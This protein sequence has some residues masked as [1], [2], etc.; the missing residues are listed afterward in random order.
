MLVALHRRTSLLHCGVRIEIHCTQLYCL[1]PAFSC[2]NL[3]WW[4]SSQQKVSLLFWS[5][6]M[7]EWIAQVQFVSSIETYFGRDIHVLPMKTCHALQQ[8]FH[9]LFSTVDLQFLLHPQD[10]VGFRPWEGTPFQRSVGGRTEKL[11]SI[12]VMLWVKPILP[13]RSY[14]LCWLKWRLFSTLCWGWRSCRTHAWT[15]LGRSATWSSSVLDC[16]SSLSQL[17][18]WH[19][20]Q[21]LS[22]HFFTS[23]STEYLITLQQMNQWWQPAPS[24]LLVGDL[25]NIWEDE[26]IPGHWSLARVDQTLAVTDGVVHIVTAQTRCGSTYT[27]PVVKGVPLLQ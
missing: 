24:F 3:L 11:K 4:A 1:S 12:S 16:L 25:V 5:L 13:L 26:T 15:F 21:V 23:W 10:C 27:R 14:R 18:R 9:N 19:L 2:L 22:H 8:S 6:I 7:L 20:C 17:K